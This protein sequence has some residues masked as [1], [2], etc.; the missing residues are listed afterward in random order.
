MKNVSVLLKRDEC[1]KRNKYII[2][3]KVSPKS[4]IHSITVPRDER[5]VMSEKR[6][7]VEK[8][9]VCSSLP[10]I[11]LP[12]R[13]GFK[14]EQRRG[15]ARET[16]EFRKGDFWPRR[17]ALAGR[18][19]ISL[20]QNGPSSPGRS[21]PTTGDVVLKFRVWHGGRRGQN[22]TVDVKVCRVRGAVHRVGGHARIVASV[23]PGHV[24]HGQYGGVRVERR[25]D[26]RAAGR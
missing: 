8:I 16:S 25:H 6:R 18:E 11:F 9:D 23:G 17:N 26:G 13:L 21:S 7:I 2:R 14:R 19:I 22:G 5:D 24:V 12:D 3:E 1:A 20:F 10:T 15:F 4:R